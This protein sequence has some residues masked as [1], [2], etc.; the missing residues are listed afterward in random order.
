MMPYVRMRAQE[1]SERF[2]LQ[3]VRYGIALDAMKSSAASAFDCDYFCKSTGIWQRAR[4][5]KEEILEYA[6]FVP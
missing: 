4:D 5:N 1:K 3:A 6:P 2:K